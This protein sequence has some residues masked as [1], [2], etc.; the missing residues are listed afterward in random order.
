MRKVLLLQLC[1]AFAL[2]LPMCEQTD[3]P[4]PAGSIRATDPEADALLQK[5]VEYRNQGKLSKA[6]GEL[7]EL[8]S[9]HGLAPNAPQAR[10]M[11]GEVY[12]R[13]NDP[14]EAFKQY[15]KVVENYQSSSLYEAALNR[16][17]AMATSAANETLKTKV[18][19]L[20]DVPME[21]TVVIE[22]LETVIRNAPYNDM[23]ATATSV[24][25]D[26]LVK[27]EQYE[28]ACAVYRRLVENYPDSRYA[29]GAQ[30]MVAKLWAASHTRGDQ[31][32]VNLANAQEAYEEF[33]LRFPNH[34][35]AKK[36]YEEAKNVR[37]LLVQQELE[38]GR[39]Y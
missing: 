3:G 4:L 1:A 24:L 20:W 30:M 33:T 7:R 31:N 18:M 39:Y 8:L 6:K 25:A 12:E 37:R 14:R 5:A 26:Y 15:T 28:A 16:Q 23:S 11:L 13:M 2:V 36:A 38:V 35:D 29:P 9:E 19:G 27:Q 22:W 10:Y 32:L 34:P 21:S 17:L